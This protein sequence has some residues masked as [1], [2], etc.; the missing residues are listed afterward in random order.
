VHVS[1]HL[2]ECGAEACALVKGGD[3]DAVG[4]LQKQFSV[5]VL[6]RKDGQDTVWRAGKQHRHCML[7]FSD[8]ENQKSR[9]RAALR[10]LTF[11]F[12][13]GKVFRD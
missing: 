7:S 9:P 8:F 12:Q 2:L 11:L 4:G 1:E 13:H 6:S 5:S 10:N 3:H